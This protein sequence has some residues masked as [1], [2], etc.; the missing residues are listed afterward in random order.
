MAAPT[1]GGFWTMQGLPP[2]VPEGTAVNGAAV[3][4]AAASG[5]VANGVRGGQ[6]GV[7]GL[8]TWSWASLGR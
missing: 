1:H 5:A 4:G 6:P 3:N 7:G 8:N 2:A